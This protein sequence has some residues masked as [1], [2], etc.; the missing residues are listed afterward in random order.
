MALMAALAAVVI[1][2]YRAASQTPPLILTYRRSGGVAGFSEELLVY[3]DGLAIYRRPGLESRAH[4]PS[5]VV[6]AFLLVLRSLEE[7]GFSG[8]EAKP[9]AADF[10]SHDVLYA[11]TGAEF[12]WVDEWASEEPLPAEVT[13]LSRLLDYAISYVL[14][15]VWVNSASQAANDVRL[16]VSLDRIVVKRGEEAFIKASILNVGKWSFSYDSP[17]PCDPDVKIQV[18]PECCVVRYTQPRV[19][20]KAYCIQMVVQRSLEPGETRINAATIDVREDAQPGIYW[21]KAS[22]PYGRSIIEVSLPFVV[23]EG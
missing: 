17:T 1:L 4:L 15:D 16:E 7:T 10:F 18:E 21:V 23:V 14:G 6:D 5:E 19:G 9:G 11:S 3:E 20:P 8:S 2:E 12:K 22:F 13:V